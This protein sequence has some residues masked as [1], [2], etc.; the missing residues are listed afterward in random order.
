VTAGVWGWSWLAL[1]AAAAVGAGCAALAAAYVCRVDAGAP[2]DGATLRAAFRAAASGRP[3][4][5]PPPLPAAA[6]AA[7]LALAGLPFALQ[8]SVPAFARIPACAVLL[9]LAL[10]DAR[11]RL[12]PD[13]LTLPLLW[14]GLLLAWAGWGPP[15]GD[16][17]AAAALGYLFP[18]GLNAVFMAC[19]G[20]AGLGGGDMKLVAALG[21]WLGWAPLPGLLLAASLAGIAFAVARRGRRAWRATLPFG[22]FLAAGGGVGLAGVPVVQFLF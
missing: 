14:A 1:P 16:A 20:R 6:C 3:A 19:R 22:P 2:V 10:I 5:R 7:L 18:R 4:P 12:L 11:S 17:V 21:A 9:T 15:L 13:A 8:P